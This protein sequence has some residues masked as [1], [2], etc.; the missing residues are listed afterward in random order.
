MGTDALRDHAESKLG[1]R[2]GGRSPDGH[3]TL[4]AAYYLGNCALTPAVVIDG[5]LKGRMDAA[6][7]DELIAKASQGK[8]A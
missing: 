3:V 1:T 5:E 4:E 8:S 2:M 7:F 6:R